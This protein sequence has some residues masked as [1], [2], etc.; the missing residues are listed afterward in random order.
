[1][2][3]KCFQ[4]LKFGTTINKCH[5]QSTKCSR[6][7]EN[8]IIQGCMKFF[9]KT[10]TNKNKRSLLQKRMFIVRGWVFILVIFL[11]I[12]TIFNPTTHPTKCNKFLMYAVNKSQKVD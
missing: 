1:M 12:I 5:S 9:E 4:L 6:N 10:N 8:K 11:L 3:Q 7:S 2:Y